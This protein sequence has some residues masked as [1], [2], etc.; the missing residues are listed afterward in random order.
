MR[1]VETE[2]EEAR[3]EGRH[4]LIGRIAMAHF[5]CYPILFVAAASAMSLAIIWQKDAILLAAQTTLPRTGVQ[6]WLIEEVALGPGDAAAF[7]V[8]M[9]PLTSVLG[10]IFVLAHATSVP[11]GLAARRAALGRGTQAAVARAR[12]LW[13][14]STLGV[15]GVVVCGGLV[16]WVVILLQPGS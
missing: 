5:L 13:I 3:F 14:V 11:W 9:R 8:I 1:A 15:A 16:G 12:N 7:E 10:A 6:R 4:A 2:S